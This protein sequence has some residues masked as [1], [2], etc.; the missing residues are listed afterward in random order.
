[1]QQRALAIHAAQAMYRHVLRRH[2]ARFDV[3]HPKIPA[4]FLIL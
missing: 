2:I 1:M 4:S 3:H